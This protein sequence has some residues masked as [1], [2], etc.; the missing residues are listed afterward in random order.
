[1]LAVLVATAN[2]PKLLDRAIRS[3]ERQT[4][5][6][7]HVYVVDDSADDCT[8]RTEHIARQHPNVEFIRNSRTKG[9]AGAW[10]DGI[11]HLLRITP[12]PTQLYVAI[13]DDDD[14]WEPE[15]LQTCLETAA[16]GQFDIVAAQLWRHEDD[17]EPKLCMPPESLDA[18]DFLV[19]NPNIQGSNLFCRLSVMLEAGLFD[20]W[21]PSC[22]D[23]DLCIRIADL[24]GVLYGTTKRTTVRH[25]ASG[26]LLR[27][28]TPGQQAKNDGLTRFFAKYQGRMSADQR[29]AFKDRATHL[30]GWHEAEPSERQQ[31]PAVA[32]PSTPTDSS[33]T[34]PTSVPGTLPHIVL[35]VIADT[36]SLD[37]LERLLGDLREVTAQPELAGFDAVV[38]ENGRAQ[39]PS[40]ELRKLAEGERKRGL[41]IHLVDRARHVADARRGRV[42]DGGASEGRYL[43]IAPARTVLQSYLYAFAKRRPG[44]IVWIVVD[45][46]RFDPLVASADGHFQRRPQPL[47]RAFRK[48]QALRD[49]DAADVVIGRC[50]GAP[51][52]PFAATVRTQMVDLV[53][54]LMWLAVQPPTAVLP[55]RAMENAALRHKRHDYY[56][57]LSRKETDRLETPFW[58]T[59]GY[60]GQTVGKAFKCLASRAERILAGEQLFRPLVVE[61]DDADSLAAGKGLQRGGNTFV[62]DIETLRLAP[63]PAPVIDDRPT[64]RSDMLWALLQERH[65]GRK[66]VTMPLAL[67]QDRSHV[68]VGELD[69]DRILDDMRGYA[70]F[71]AFEAVSEVFVSD[72]ELHIRLAAESVIDHFLSRV[73]KFMNE[74]LAAFRLSFYRIRGLAR[75]LR[76]LAESDAVWWHDEPYEPARVALRAFC[77]RLD[78]AYASN[79]LTRIE[80][81]AVLLDNAQLRTFLAK[82]PDQ[83][84][85]HRARLADVTELAS[86]FNEGRIANAKAVAERLANPA[87]PLDALGCGS[88]GVALTDGERVYKVFDYWKSWQRD[89]TL[90]YLRTLVGAWQDTRSLYPLLAFREQGHDALLIY[91]FEPSKPYTGGN[92][93][94]LVDLIAECW[95]FRVACHNLHPDNLRVVGDR[96]RLI[97]YGSD[98]RPLEDDHELAT[99]CQQAWLSLRCHDRADLKAMIRQALH[100][101]R[102]PELE[103]FEAF[104]DAVLRVTGERKT[105]QNIALELSGEPK[106]AL[107]YG[108]GN[109]A[110]AEALADRGAQV[111]G[112]DRD[113]TREKRW[114]ER[115]N[116]ASNLRIT[117]AR[118][119]VFNSTPFDLVVCQRVLCTVDDA[120]MRR[121]LQD[122]RAAVAADGRVVVTMCD[123][124]CTLGGPTPEADRELPA[125]VRYEDTFVWHKT[126]RTS[127][128]KR[129]EVHRPEEALLAEFAR[130]GLRVTKR[131]TVPTVD[132]VNFEPASDHLAFELVPNEDARR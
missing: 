30:F 6:P 128:R 84:E 113:R 77:D 8:A 21:L 61:A 121:I 63:N 129:R 87:G 120:E 41:R 12:D 24:P 62:L 17:A 65:L 19:G 100:D 75:V 55:D 106:R 42:H 10:N 23:R 83:L 49:G 38:L 130:V 124:H 13:L 20:E 47:L 32:P 29:A 122:V 31:L 54:S 108:C 82:L 22:T 91:S 114:R 18:A 36:E 4:L 2:R 72:S 112:Y 125:G 56:Y 50:T 28:S 27:L 35:G 45:D 9:A 67:H 81:A 80:R 15:H 53:A 76:D 37:D 118:D 79:A 95:Q 126:V 5:S 123:P 69:V 46:L 101:T 98:I 105:R 11:D 78:H 102:L 94:G 7:A 14:E 127:G 43:G 66:V 25:Y 132:L 119:E 44:A 131:T 64:R 1:M 60:D 3:I 68:E 110:V 96:V 34:S 103:G 40:R 57:D 116:G 104:H 111:L 85:G 99:M 16:S 33:D 26:S 74:R 86:G 93:R 73:R 39:G 51:P 52:L 97:D 115:R 109:G 90:D 88:E 59:P 71:S 58:A 92:G 48:L 107:D 70:L 89:S 117:S